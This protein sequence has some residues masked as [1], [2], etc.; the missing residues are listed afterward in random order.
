M[1]SFMLKACSIARDFDTR[2][3]VSRLQLARESGVKKHLSKFT[4]PQIGECLKHHP[5]L[6]DPWEQECQDIRGSGVW[7]FGKGENRGY[8]VGFV[9]DEMGVTNIEHFVSRTDACAEYIHRSV[10]SILNR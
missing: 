6:L 7:F 3:N 10:L 4:V 8:I 2:G 1:T 9:D 5:E